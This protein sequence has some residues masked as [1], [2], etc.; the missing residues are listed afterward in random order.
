MCALYSCG[1]GGMG[2]MPMLGC[3]CD[4]MYG[5]KPPMEEP[6]PNTE[7]VEELAPAETSE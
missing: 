5:A 4:V 2:G 1:N 7:P 6:A 3:A